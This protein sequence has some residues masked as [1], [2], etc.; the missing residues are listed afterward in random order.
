M[1]NQVLWLFQ[2]ENINFSDN[3]SHTCYFESTYPSKASEGWC[4]CAPANTALQL[5]SVNSSQS[6]GLVDPSLIP[7][8]AALPTTAQSPRATDFL[9]RR[10]RRLLH[11][12]PGWHSQHSRPPS[13][14]FN[15]IEAATFKPLRV[16]KQF[17]VLSFSSGQA[18]FSH[19]KL[20]D[21]FSRTTKLC[22]DY[23]FLGW[24]MTK[25]E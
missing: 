17:Q 10:D 1:N 22:W 20:F 19:T 6:T 24:K 14:P 15:G 12:W 3:R 8:I 13:N 25:N 4:P 5:Q 16:R 7:T 2:H 9:Q 18:C 11:P 23:F 21:F